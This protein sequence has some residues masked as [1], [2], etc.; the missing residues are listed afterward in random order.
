MEVKWKLLNSNEWIKMETV[1]FQWMGQ[2]YKIDTDLSKT[3]FGK[4][5][6]KYDYKNGIFTKKYDYKNGKIWKTWNYTFWQKFQKVLFHFLVKIPKSMI[7]IFEKNSKKYYS[8][9]W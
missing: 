4:N 5:S 3:L 9:F 8:T 2:Y 7:T 6:K 1:K